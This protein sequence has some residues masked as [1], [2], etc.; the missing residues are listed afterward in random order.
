MRSTMQDANDQLSAL[1]RQQADAQRLM[2]TGLI[3]QAT[4]QALRDTG[5]M[6]NENPQVEFDLLVSVDGREPY[7]VTHRQVVSRLVISNFQPGA[8]IP[9]RV[10][11][12]DPTR[13]LIG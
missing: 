9:V 1:S 3:G 2:A 11:P 5:M 6:I 7:P 8:S 10:D 13:V 12:A 4:V